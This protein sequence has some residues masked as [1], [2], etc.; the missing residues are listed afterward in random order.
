MSNTYFLLE[1][2]VDPHIF[3]KKL[4]AFDVVAAIVVVT[5]PELLSFEYAIF[6]YFQ[7]R[8]HPGIHPIK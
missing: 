7:L 6:R 2:L 8:Y 3:I 1:A 4:E 5:V